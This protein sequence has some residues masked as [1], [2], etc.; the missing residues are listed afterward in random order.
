A[1]NR[2]LEEAVEDGRFRADLYYR[3]SVFPIHLPPLRERG[4][5]IS[6]LAEYFLQRLAARVGRRFTGIEPTSLEQLQAF[7]WPGNIR[8]LQNVIE[9]S[10]ILS[11]QPVLGIPASVLVEKQP[12]VARASKLD[13]ALD[14]SE[15]QLI[16][17]ALAAARGRV[18]GSTGAATSLGVPASTLESKIR[19]LKIDKLRFRSYPDA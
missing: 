16:E 18:S 4:E 6:V 3:L 15:Q 14:S 12:S 2:N 1:T 11:D 10:A 19:R 5:D 13:A 9:H 7:S 17:Q 8:Q